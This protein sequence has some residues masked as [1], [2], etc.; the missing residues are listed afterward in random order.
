VIPGV[1]RWRMEEALKTVIPAI[2]SFVT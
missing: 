2:T 1:G